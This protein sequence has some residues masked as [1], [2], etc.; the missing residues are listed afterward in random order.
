MIVRCEVN[1]GYT[2]TPRLPRP[3]LFPLRPRFR[4]RLPLRAI[5]LIPFRGLIG[6]LLATAVPSSSS[7]PFLLN[8][9]T[10]QKIASRNS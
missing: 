1:Q 9:F 6:Q 8:S 3:P 10:L 2:I 4:P 7:T 5:C